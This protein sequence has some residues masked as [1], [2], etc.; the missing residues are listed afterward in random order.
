MKFRAEIDITG[1]LSADLE[2]VSQEEADEAL[3]EYIVYTETGRTWPWHH[4]TLL[5]TDKR[6]LEIE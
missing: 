2:A 3:R 1:T 6:V 4:Y 5:I